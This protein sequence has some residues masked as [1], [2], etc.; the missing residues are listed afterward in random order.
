[1]TPMAEFLSTN[2]RIHMAYR[3][4]TVQCIKGTF[5]FEGCVTRN[6]KG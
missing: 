2:L 4:T 3:I 5:L 6:N 1:V